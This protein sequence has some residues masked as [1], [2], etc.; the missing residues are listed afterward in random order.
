MTQQE[1]DKPV[2]Q[3]VV[4]VAEPAAPPKWAE[5]LIMASQGLPVAGPFISK[6]LLYL[7]IISS[8]LTALTAFVL[9]VANVLKGISNIA[10]LTNFSMK[11]DDFKNGKIMYW[12][13]Y[14]SM[15][16][17]KKAVV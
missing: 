17:A 3:A 5:D 9:T 2:Q 7:G 13:K 12:L 15:F 14:F 1:V 16:N 6:A 11:V 4:Q 10:G 8:I